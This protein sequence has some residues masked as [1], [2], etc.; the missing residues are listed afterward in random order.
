MEN[1]L[2]ALNPFTIYVSLRQFMETG[3]GVL[4]WIMG[5]T[6]VMWT[7][8]VER[9]WYFTFTFPSARRRTVSAWENRADHQSWQAHQIRSALVSEIRLETDQFLSIIKTLVAIAP[10]FGLLGTVTG[11]VE[12]FDIMAATGAS[13]ARAM[14]SGVSKATIPTMAGMVAA[15]SGL[16]FSTLLDRRAKRAI[17][18]LEDD[19][20]IIPT[21]K[22]SKAAPLA[23]GV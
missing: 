20:E 13:N 6:F 16:Y 8:I 22:A 23:S 5:V 2:D 11:M 19:L 3:G 4:I 12:V 10:L 18:K 14:A 7:L 9:F 21:D 1:F 15:I 17:E